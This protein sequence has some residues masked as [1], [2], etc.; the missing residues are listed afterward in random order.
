MSSDDSTQGS[1][2]ARRLLTLN[3]YMEAR[4][5]DSELLCI[6]RTKPITTVEQHILQDQKR[7]P[8]SSGEFSWLLSGITLATK[9]ISARVRRAG[10]SDILG[11]IGVTNVQG[12]VQQKLDV[13]AND[14]LRHSLSYRESIG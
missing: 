1:N 3:R 2:L 7:F 11:E 14:V 9:M 10:L 8:G 12:E 5:I 4:S 13:Y 6:S